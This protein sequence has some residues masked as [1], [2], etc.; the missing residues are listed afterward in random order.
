MPQSSRRYNRV[1]CE[2]LLYFDAMGRH[3]CFRVSGNTR[4]PL[5]AADLLCYYYF[6]SNSRPN[7][8]SVSRMRNKPF[9]EAE[10]ATGV[11]GRFA[12]YGAL[13]Q[14]EEK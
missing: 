12:S 8:D 1:I 11:T 14:T 3:A 10:T 9:V 2:W 4:L 6:L 7:N 5:C 13:K